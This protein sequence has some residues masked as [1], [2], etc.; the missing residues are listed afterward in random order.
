MTSKKK[1]TPTDLRVKYLQ[2]FGVWPPTSQYFGHGA[3]S[4]VEDYVRWLEQQIIDGPEIE[5]VKE[6]VEVYD[7]SK[8]IDI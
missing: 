4:T 3:T 6:E 2:E 7:N 5:I 8:Y 1:M